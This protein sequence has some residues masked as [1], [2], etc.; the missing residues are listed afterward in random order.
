M[1]VAKFIYQQ[2]YC[3]YLS[4]GECIVYDRGEFCNKVVDILNKE[5]KV[6][7]RVIS[8]GRPQGNGQAESFVSSLKDKMYAL[9]VEGGSHLMPNNWDET[10]L[11]RALQILRSD[12]SIATGY[13]PIELL[14]GRKPV[15]PIELEYNDIDFTG[16]E[17]TAPLVDALQ[18]IHDAAFGIA[19]KKIKKEQERYAKAYDKRY[20]TNPIKLR[21]GQRVQVIHTIN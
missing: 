2:I 18:R 21:V 1:S 6:N 3:R 12:P 9:M 13:A 4:P 17:L 19:C 8:A 11:Y 5:Y 16:T 14:L 7:V 10:L 20:Q 15:F